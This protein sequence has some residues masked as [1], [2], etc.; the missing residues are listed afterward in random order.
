DAPRG[1]RYAQQGQP[2]WQDDDGRWHYGRPRAIGWQ[3]D[4]GNWHPGVVVRYGWRDRDGQW[5]ES[6]AQTPDQPGYGNN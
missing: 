6:P 3:D 2:G 1:D 4:D 5:R